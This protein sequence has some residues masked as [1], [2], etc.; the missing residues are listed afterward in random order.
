MTYNINQSKTDSVV[1]QE[2]FACGDGFVTR[3]E[4]CDVN[5][6]IGVTDPQ[7]QECQNQQ[8]I[9]TLVTTRI[10]NRACVNFNYSNPDPAVGPGSGQSC[11]VALQELIQP[12]C[13]TL[14]IGAYTQ[15]TNTTNVPVSCTAKNASS[16]TRVGIDCGNGTTLS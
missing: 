3:T 8:G 9:C 11:Y 6:Q 2:P 10:L 13:D 4:Q 7:Q 16:T 5:G 14:T 1:V 12:S 15:N